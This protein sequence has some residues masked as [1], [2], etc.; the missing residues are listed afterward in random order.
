MVYGLD[1]VGWQLDVADGKPLPLTQ[2]E[3]DARRRGAAIE[4]RIYAEDPVRFLPSP[5]TLTHLRV[6]AGPWVRD[7]SGCYEGATIPVFYDPLISKLVAWGV[8]RGD[9]L[10]R[11]R[12][13]LDEY[14]VRGIQTNLPFHRRCLRHSAFQTGEYDTGFIDRERAVLCVDADGP[15][16]AADAV[17]AAAAI[18]SAARSGLVTGAPAATGGRASGWRDRA[19]PGRLS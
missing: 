2:K 12:R 3:L 6:P 19:R 7:D 16:D 15:G 17:V 18:D 5:G 8:D 9:A 1:L 11:M 14:V 13:A 4:C 10:A